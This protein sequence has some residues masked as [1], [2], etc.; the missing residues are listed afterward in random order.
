MKVGDRVILVQSCSS[1]CEDCKEH[2]GEAMTVS[3]VYKG[4]AMI[5]RVKENIVSWPADL[6]IK[7]EEEI[8]TNEDFEL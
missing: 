7:E 3:H 1:D 5:I 2:M 4:I 8:L 6:F